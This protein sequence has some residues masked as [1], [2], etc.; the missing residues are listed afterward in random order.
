MIFRITS[1]DILDDSHEPAVVVLNAIMGDFFPKV[2]S[3]AANRAG[4]GDDFGGCAF[5]G[6]L[7]PWEAPLP[8]NCV[9]CVLTDGETALI[10]FDEYYYYLE[11]FASDY[12]KDYP[13]QKE[14][15]EELLR[16]VRQGLCLK[17]YKE[18]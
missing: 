5:Q 11:I 6:S 4:F 18:K 9:E 15:I 1:D 7:D 17:E 12:I 16:Q 2:L 8:P 13:E 3:L 10:T 14:K